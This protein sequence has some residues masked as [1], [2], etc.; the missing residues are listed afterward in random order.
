MLLNEFG[1]ENARPDKPEPKKTIGKAS[2]Q[3]Q[4]VINQFLKTIATC[5]MDDELKAVL[6]FRIWGSDPVIFC[7]LGYLDIATLLKCKIADVKRWEEDAMWNIEQFLKRSDL[8]TITDKFIR[9]GN[10]K[11]II[12]QRKGIKISL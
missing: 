6:R 11:K 7:P 1:K 10:L 8:V 5:P 2:Y 12:E 9:D 4:A 3:H